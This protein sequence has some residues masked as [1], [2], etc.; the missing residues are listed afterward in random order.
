MTTRTEGNRRH[1]TILYGD[2]S[3]S[4]SVIVFNIDMTIGFFITNR[5]NF[6]CPHCILKTLVGDQASPR[7]LPLSVFEKS[8][9]EGMKLGFN[10]V[11]LTGG[12]PLLYPQFAK[13]VKIIRKHNYTFGFASNGWLYKEYWEALEHNNNGLKYVT[14]SLDGSTAE[15]HD[16]VREKRG[17]FEKV[18]EATDFYQ[19]NKIDVGVNFL[20][21][22]QNRHQ[23]VDTARLCA[24][25]GVK[26]IVYTGEIPLNNSKLTEDQKAEARAD[27][28]CAR[29]ELG[30]SMNIRT[31]STLVA[32]KSLSHIGSC[33]SYKGQRMVIDFDGGMFFCCNLYQQC[34][35][36]PLISKI[37]FEKA[38]QINMKVIEEFYR[39]YFS[40]LL[41]NMQSDDRN[42][43]FCNQ[44]IGNML[45]IR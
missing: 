36:K 31:G 3:F 30:K 25:M 39:Q 15:V 29:K 1:S 10:H 40:G 21:S 9:K 35:N 44:H 26:G 7:D 32:F 2:F 28:D 16:S 14:L 17:S 5:C 24:K 18:M 20:L 22:P 6:N 45:Q 41:D 19:K 43:N 4:E 13:L 8:I 33:P 34:D 12:E 38:F 27:I 37:G 23:V 11:S 42:C